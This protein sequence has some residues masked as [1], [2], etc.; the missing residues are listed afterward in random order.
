MRKSGIRSALALIALGAFLIAATLALFSGVHH[1]VRGL[2]AKHG[3]VDQP[4]FDG[5]GCGDV[6]FL[7]HFVVPS[8]RPGILSMASFGSESC[9]V[10]SH[11]FPLLVRPPPLY[12]AATGVQLS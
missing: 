2:A 1:T 12:S 7:A 11:V 8:P 4:C 3:V 10:I 6:V 5:T 9:A